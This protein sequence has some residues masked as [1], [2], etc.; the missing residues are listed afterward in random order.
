MVIT[1]QIWFD[2][3]RQDGNENGKVSNEFSL[4]EKMS[5]K[6]TFP[7]ENIPLQ[8]IPSWKITLFLGK[9]SPPKKKKVERVN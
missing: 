2:L 4:C 3:I 5:L 7:L 8:N 1:I 6:R 9:L